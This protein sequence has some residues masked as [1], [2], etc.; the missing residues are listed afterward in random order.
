[1]NT[2]RLYSMALLGLLNCR[3]SLY[4]QPEPNMENLL[5]RILTIL[6]EFT[7]I[8]GEKQCRR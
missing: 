7:P 6:V 4:R 5:R 1:M 8:D 3:D 2:S